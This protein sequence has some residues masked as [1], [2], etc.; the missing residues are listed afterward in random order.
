MPGKGRLTLTGRLGDVM[1]ESAHAALAHLRVDPAR[2]GADRAR[3][4]ACDVHLHVPE[5]ATAKDGPSA[6]VAVFTALLSAVTG[7]ALRADVALTGEISLTG[8]VL[9]VGGVR[10]KLL[11]A[12]RSGV[13]RVILPEANRADIPEDLS[14]E[15]VLVSAVDEVVRA[16]FPAAPPPVEGGNAKAKG[17]RTTKARTTSKAKAPRGA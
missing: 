17:A 5:A 8:R 4:A 9:P 6:G 3:L 13:R 14:I 7:A 10:A 16:V 2:Y 11:A 1:R 12:E 15:V